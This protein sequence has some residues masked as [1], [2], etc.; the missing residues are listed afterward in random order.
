MHLFLNYLTFPQSLTQACSQKV[1]VG[2]AMRIAGGLSLIYYE[3]S[4]YIQR[5]LIGNQE[6]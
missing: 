5:S 4:M 6:F 1:I 3:N 2:E